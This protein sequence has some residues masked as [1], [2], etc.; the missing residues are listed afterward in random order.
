MGFA[1]PTP[2]VV[3]ILLFIHMQAVGLDGTASAAASPSKSHQHLLA[4]P[5]R[6]PLHVSAI[7]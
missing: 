7:C 3:I 5:P 2:K 4:P 6:A 1:P